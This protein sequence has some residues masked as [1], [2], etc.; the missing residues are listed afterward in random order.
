MAVTVTT[1]AWA[2][3]VD[4]VAVSNRSTSNQGAR[5]RPFIL[6]DMSTQTEYNVYKSLGGNMKQL[7]VRF[8]EKQT[9]QLS[10]IVDCLGASTSDVARAAMALGMNQIKEI[11][12]RDI[13][14]AQ[15]LVSFNAFKAMQ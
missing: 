9:S 6:L 7:P 3:T 4:V 15:Q 14:A 11:A 1:E 10:D 12:S 8:N 5:N 2:D 13:E